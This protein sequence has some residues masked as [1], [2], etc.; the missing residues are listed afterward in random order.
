[1]HVANTDAELHRPDMLMGRPGPVKDELAQLFRDGGGMFET[2]FR[3]GDDE[4]I[5]S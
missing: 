2:S 5:A 1:M 3:Q 4:F